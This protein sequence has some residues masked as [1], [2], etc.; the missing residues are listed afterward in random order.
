MSRNAHFGPSSSENYL[1]FLKPQYDTSTD[2]AEHSK[3]SQGFNFQNKTHEDLSPFVSEEVPSNTEEKNQSKKESKVGTTENDKTTTSNDNF[4][5][6]PTNDTNE[7]FAGDLINTEAFITEKNHT[8]DTT[9]EFEKTES[10]ENSDKIKTNENN[11]DMI[12]NLKTNETAETEKDLKTRTLE[13]VEGGLSNKS[14]TTLRSYAE[15][16][17]TAS[18]KVKADVTKKDVNTPGEGQEIALNDS[19]DVIKTNKNI[20]QTTSGDGKNVDVTVTKMERN[21]KVEMR[22]KDEMT[23]SNDKCKELRTNNTLEEFAEDIVDTDEIKTEK[24]YAEYT[25]KQCETIKCNENGANVKTSE[26][27]PEI[28]NNLTNTE[29]T[30]TE[31]DLQTPTTEKEE[32]TLSD[33]SNQG[34]RTNDKLPETSSGSTNRYEETSSNENNELI[35]NDTPEEFNEELRTDENAVNTETNMTNKV[36]M[37]DSTNRYEETSSNE[38]NELI[39]ND[40]PEEFNEELRTDENAVNTETNMTNKVLMEDS[41]NRYEETSSNENNELI[42]NDTPEEFNE[43]LRTDENAVNTETNMTNKVLM[44]D[45]T[46]RYEETSSN[47]NNELITNDTPEEFNEE[48]RT[49]EN[50]VNTETNMTNKV[51][52][53]DSTNRYEETSSNEN[54]EL[55]TNDTPEE[56]N[57]ELRTDENAVNT[58]TNMTNKVLMEDSTNRYEETS[59]NENNELITNDTPEEFNEELRTD[60]NA[61]NT[62]TNMTN[63]VLMEDSTNR[64]EETS[65]NENNELI[66]NDTPEEFNEELRTDENAVN[67]ETNMTNKVLMEDSTNRY[68]E[69]SSN[70]NNELITND[71]PEEFNEELRTDENAVNTESNMTNKV[72][73][74]DSTNRYEKTSSNENNELITNDT[75]EEFAEDIV[76]TE[77]FKTEKDYAEYTNEQCETTQSNENGAKVKTNEKVPEI[78][79][80]LTNTEET[81]TEKDLQTTTTEKEEKTLSDKSN[82]VMRTNDKLPETSSGSTN[83]YEETLSNENNELITNDTPEEFNEEL[84]TDENA[85]NTETNM[86]NKVLMEDSTNRYEETSSNENNEL[87]TNDIPEVFAEDIVDTEEFKTE[88]DYAEY[89]N[90]QC[91]T[92]KSNEN[93]AKVKTNEKVPEILDNLTN[94]EETATEIDLQTPTTEKEEKTLSDKSNQGVRTNDKLP[95]TSSGIRKDKNTTLKKSCQKA[96]KIK[97]REKKTSVIKKRSNK[98]I[99]NLES[100][101]TVQKENDDNVGKEENIQESTSD[102]RSKEATEDQKDQGASENYRADEI[103]G[104]NAQNPENHHLPHITIQTFNNIHLTLDNQ[105][106]DLIKDT[107]K[108]IETALKSEKFTAVI[109]RV[110]ERSTTKPHDNVT[111]DCQSLQENKNSGKGASQDNNFQIKEAIV[112]EAIEPSKSLRNSGEMLGGNSENKDSRKLQVQAAGDSNNLKN[113]KGEIERHGKSN[114]GVITDSINFEETQTFFKSKTDIEDKFESELEAEDSKMQ[115][116]T[117]NSSISKNDTPPKAMNESMIYDSSNIA[118]NQSSE[119]HNSYATSN[120]EDR[121]LN[122]ELSTI[123]DEDESGTKMEAEDSKMQMK[124]NHSSI[125]ENDNDVPT[126][127]TPP[128]ALHESMISAGLRND[129]SNIASNQ[130][131]ETHSS[132]ATTNTERRTNLSSYAEWRSNIEVATQEDEESAD[133]FSNRLRKLTST[134]AYGA[135][136]DEL[137]R[138]RLVIGVKD[139]QARKKKLSTPNLSLQQAIDNMKIIRVYHDAIKING[140]AVEI[141]N[142]TQK[143]NQPKE[144]MRS[145]PIPR[146]RWQIVCIDLF[147]I[148]KSSFIVMADNLTKYWNVEQLQ[149]ETT[150]DT[151]LQIKKIFSRHRI[152]ELVISDNG[153]QFTS[154]LFKSFAETYG[155]HQYT[156][157]PY[158]PRG[159]G[160]AEA[161]IMFEPDYNPRVNGRE[162]KLFNKRVTDHTL[163]DLTTGYIEETDS[164]LET[165]L[166]IEDDFEI[167]TLSHNNE[168]QCDDHSFDD[169]QLNVK[170]SYGTNRRKFEASLMKPSKFG[171]PPFKFTTEFGCANDT[172]NIRIKCSSGMANRCATLTSDEETKNDENERDDSPQSGANTDEIQNNSLDFKILIDK[173]SKMSIGIQNNHTSMTLRVC[174]PGQFAKIDVENRPIEIETLNNN[175]ASTSRTPL[176]S[177][178]EKNTQNSQSIS[179]PVEEASIKQRQ[180]VLP[181]LTDIQ[182]NKLNMNIPNTSVN[183][184]VYE[185]YGKRPSHK[186]SI[187]VNHRSNQTILPEPTKYIKRKCGTCSASADG[188][189]NME[190]NSTPNSFIKVE[191]RKR[192]HFEGVYTC[193]SEKRKRKLEDDYPSNLHNLR[194]AIDTLID[195]SGLRNLLEAVYGERAAVHML[196]GKA[197]QRTFRG[198]LLIDRCLNEMVVFELIQKDSEFETLVARSEKEY[199]PCLA[200]ERD[201]NDGELTETL[202]M[203]HHKLCEK[204]DRIATKSKTSELW[205]R[206]QNMIKI[207]SN[208]IRADR[209]VGTH[210][211]KSP[212]YMPTAVS[213]LFGWLISRPNPLNTEHQPVSSFRVSIVDAIAKFWELES[214]DESASDNRLCNDLANQLFAESICK[215][216]GYYQVGLPWKHN[217][218]ILVSNKSDAQKCLNRLERKLTTNQELSIAYHQALEEFIDCNYIEEV[219]PDNQTERHLEYY[220]PYRPVVEESSTFKVKSVFDASAKDSNGHSLNDC[221]ILS[222][223]IIKGKMLMQILWKLSL[224]WDQSITDGAFLNE[225]KSIDLQKVEQL[226]IPRCYFRRQL[227]VVSLHVFC[228]ASKR[229]YSAVV[230]VTSDSETSMILDTGSAV[231]ILNS[232]DFTAVSGNFKHLQPPT[233][234]LKSY[235]G[236]EIKMQIKLNNQCELVSNDLKLG[237]G[238]SC[239]AFGDMRTIDPEIE[240]V[241][242]KR[243]ITYISE[244]RDDPK[245]LRAVEF[246]LTTED[247]P[248]IIHLS[249]HGKII[250]HWKHSQIVIKN[251]WKR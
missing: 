114:S 182:E 175:A 166:K 178:A 106:I 173:F 122:K 33:K 194:G 88:K 212:R 153:P 227:D 222:P 6:L 207:S 20:V 59:S 177:N 73:M 145:Q 143:N 200:S 135:M 126:E 219:I 14:K 64:Y 63:K 157:S 109:A 232:Y 129:S 90:E 132:Y 155:F 95:E 181:N 101:K 82:Q 187:K 77:E 71:T 189:T 66:T 31:K 11:H 46:N 61:V 247:S 107:D 241:I 147:I 81:A 169:F 197:M 209:S 19:S 72:L 214:I 44:E 105:A 55:I 158:H 248:S 151:I 94:T 146:T 86:T 142:I 246:L 25:N 251:V 198:H 154:K 204:G 236:N 201:L 30:A 172:E 3:T 18:V 128:T 174:R 70:E 240:S 39:T 62:E 54:N 218:P 199:Q 79:N 121:Y 191:I 170:K 223:V 149:D 68:E 10:N 116:E 60:E 210:V 216:Q 237:I 156:S 208:F 47:E 110:N 78:V 211:L 49:D 98:T 234:K 120:T 13:K 38:N 162:A 243:P 32:K 52:M 85:V 245:P 164:T 161:A 205:F 130:F 148:K 167:S 131:T 36:L 136:T 27:V 56:F 160:T 159:N 91:E 185:G 230:Y 117:S 74:E 124:T 5:G 23:A 34:M 203:I 51:L 176:N 80:N 141:N 89:T 195:G 50:A 112:N 99:S 196:S 22:E 75:P 229:A 242:N 24:D 76:D 138:D 220:L 125:S 16:L 4:K 144:A 69:T 45:S 123:T 100:S 42:T 113:E 184:I 93:G 190:G 35:T 134:C 239:H 8:E 140:N 183:V 224:D 119:K 165:L 127:E 238:R 12:S 137:I 37:E 244:D 21:S 179:S 58:E 57:E 96:I 65:S 103:D 48:L 40:T 217:H 115:M 83:R 192:R 7:E 2:K 26:K 111:T 53:E 231:T 213:F 225:I 41:T 249:P 29:E 180:K 87:I 228:D 67:T 102:N 233:V 206:Y 43:E 226:E 152:P 108:I 188:N 92:I 133:N 202:N 193:G 9:K 215:T 139:N 171:G 17:K 118:G 250:G 168:E 28:L 235:M 84:R 163:L 186:Y 15:V 104:C 97:K 221:L 1:S 150:E